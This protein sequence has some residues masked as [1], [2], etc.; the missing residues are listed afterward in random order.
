MVLRT[1][2]RRLMVVAAA[3][4]VDAPVF[5]ILFL[6]RILISRVSTWSGGGSAF[7]KGIEHHGDYTGIPW[8][9]NGDLYDASELKY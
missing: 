9:D 4:S 3:V 5:L 1:R 2:N 7:L 8:N 6:V